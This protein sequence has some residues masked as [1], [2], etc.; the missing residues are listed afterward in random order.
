MDDEEFGK[1]YT[2]LNRIAAAILTASII[3]S[4]TR[5]PTL[6]E[7]QTTFADCYMIVDPALGTEEQNSFQER[8]DK[9]E[10]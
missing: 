4:G 1:V 10:W 3:N 5:K 7:V 9:K 2:S 6:K 8:L